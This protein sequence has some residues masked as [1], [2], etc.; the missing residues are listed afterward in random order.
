MKLSSHINGEFFLTL[1]G[2]AC[3]KMSR[4]YR[5]SVAHLS[6]VE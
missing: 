4:T 5:T 6:D 3:L 1:D 2:G